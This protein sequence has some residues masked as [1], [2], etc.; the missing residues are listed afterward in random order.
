MGNR[1]NMRKTVA[2]RMWNS[3]NNDVSTDNKQVQKY[4]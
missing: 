2:K 1:T 3:I 4:Y